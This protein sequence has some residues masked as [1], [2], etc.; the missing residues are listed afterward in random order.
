MRILAASAFGPFPS[1]GGGGK[2]PS[3]WGTGP[4]CH[5]R[6]GAALRTEL[7][8]QD[9]GVLQVGGIESLSEPVVDVGE[10]CA[11]FITTAGIAKQPSKTH[12]RAQLPR[13]GPLLGGDRAPQPYASLCLRAVRR[14]HQQQSF[15]GDALD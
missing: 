1:R 5:G 6:Y 14:A 9:L 13:L 2:S 12:R 11:G 3:R 8:E 4:C 10:H 7:I 15:A